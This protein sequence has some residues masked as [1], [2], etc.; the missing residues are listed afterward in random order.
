MAYIFCAEN[1]RDS[2]K[3]YSPDLIVHGITKDSRVH[4]YESL[5]SK[6]IDIF[7]IG[8]GLSKEAFMQEFAWSVLEWATKSRKNVIIDGVTENP[9]R[10]LNM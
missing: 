4:E 9:S 2:I 6:K 1:V 8:P 5:F 3:G 7:I 10:K